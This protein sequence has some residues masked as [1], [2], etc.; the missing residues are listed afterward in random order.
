MPMLIILLG[1]IFLSVSSLVASADGSR[2][3]VVK[4]AED[5]PAPAISLCARK[6]ALGPEGREVGCLMQRHKGRDHS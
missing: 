3:T 1:V 2:P 4:K 6:V 5:M